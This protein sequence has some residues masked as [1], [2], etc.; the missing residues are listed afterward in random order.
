MVP[1]FKGSSF[2]EFD[3]P[4]VDPLT[5]SITFSISAQETHGLILYMQPVVCVW[6]CP[7]LFGE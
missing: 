4:A 2:L 7:F 1:M 6:I 3:S 5:I